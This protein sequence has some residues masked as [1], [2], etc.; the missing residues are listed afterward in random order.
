MGR[1]STGSRGDVMPKG[2]LIYADHPSASTQFALLADTARAQGSGTDGSAPGIVSFEE[3]FI[4][5]PGAVSIDSGMVLAGTRSSAGTVTTTGS[6]AVTW[7]GETIFAPI[8]R[9]KIDGI[10]TGGILTGQ[11]TVGLKTNASTA[12]AASISIRIR[13]NSTASTGDAA[14]W[15]TALAYTAAIACTTA[16]IFRTFEF[17]HLLTSASINA[18]PFGI[19]LGVRSNL[20]ATNIIGRVMEA[21]YIQGRYQPGT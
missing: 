19:A 5:Y 1:R 3:E 17:P 6:A 2:N 20:A 14:A 7:G 18:V 4:Y 11:I 10:A 16:E 13:N 12:D 15:A 9:G 21:S 8:G